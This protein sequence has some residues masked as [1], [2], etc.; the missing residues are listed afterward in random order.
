MNAGTFLRS[1]QLLEG[2]FF[3]NTI[4]FITEYNEKGAMGFVVNRLFPRSLNELQAFNKCLPFPLYEGGPADQEHLFFIHRRPDLV[5]D[6]VPVAGN[7]FIGGNF[8]QAVT[9][10]NNGTITEKDVRIFIGY[11]GWDKGELEAE[12]KEGSWLASENEELFR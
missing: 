3:E 9:H 12:I 8:Q 7:I 10:I 4:I 2:D 1:T 6:G 5:A 11:C